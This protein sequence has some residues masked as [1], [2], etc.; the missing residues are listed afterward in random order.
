MAE[1]GGKLDLLQ[2]MWDWTK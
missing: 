1:K 2:Q